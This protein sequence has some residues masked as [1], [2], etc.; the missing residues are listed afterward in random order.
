MYN[1]QVRRARAI[2]LNMRPLPVKSNEDHRAVYEAI[3]SGNHAAAGAIHR[4]HRQHASTVL[5]ELLKKLG[6]NSL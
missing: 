4:N 3:K 1:D 6:L 2:T 5:V